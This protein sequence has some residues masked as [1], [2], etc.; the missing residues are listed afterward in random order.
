MKFKIKTINGVKKF[1]PVIKKDTKR[2]KD[3]QAGE[4]KKEGS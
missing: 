1:V 2:K 4:K 3:L